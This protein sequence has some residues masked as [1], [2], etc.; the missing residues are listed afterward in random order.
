[1]PDQQCNPPP[2]IMGSLDDL[3]KSFAELTSAIREL[4]ERLNPVLVNRG[5]ETAVKDELATVLSCSDVAKLI[6]LVTM[7]V[8]NKTVYVRS[9]L[10]RLDV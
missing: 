7:G 6:Q 3:Q 1:M 10:E 2:Q 5:A 4:G 8:Y 9:L